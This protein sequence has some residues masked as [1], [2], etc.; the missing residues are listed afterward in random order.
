MLELQSVTYEIESRL[1]LREVSCSF[2]NRKYGLVGA[3][4]AGKT[5]LARLLAGE[6]MPSTGRVQRDA[7][8]ALLRQQEDRGEGRCGDVLAQ[9]WAANPAATKLVAGLLQ[10]LAAATRLSHLSGGEWMRLRLARA[11]ATSPSFLVL[12]EPTNDLDSDGREVVLRLLREFEGGV[13]AISHDRELLREVDEVLELKASGLAR[14]GAGFDSYWLERTAERERQ[15]SE[16]DRA[17]REKR[18]AGRERQAKLESQDR[19]ARGGERKAKAGGM[20]RIFAQ[21][22]KRRA[23]VTRGKLKQQ[24]D[25][26]VDEAKEELTEALAALETD[27]FMRLDFESEA[28]PESR[29][30]FEAR[31]LS[32]RFPGASEELWPGGLNFLMRGR[33]RWHLRGAN[34]SGKTTLL[35]LLMGEQAG[36][37][38]GSLWRSGRPFVY[39]DQGL[40]LLRD[41]ISVI[42]NFGE[43]S[44]FTPVTLRNE[45]A[46]YGFK[47]DKV[48]QRVG[49]LSGGERLRA[50]LAR[51][52]LS[53]AI[54]QMILLD[55]PTNNLDFQSMDLLEA[56]LSRYRGLLVLVSHDSVFVDQVAITDVFEIPQHG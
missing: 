39:L 46:F 2:G 40:T 10:P 26:A 18:T 56:A 5:T 28:S 3:N 22:Q 37:V 32:V 23:Q 20:P 27:P 15:S 24:S 8:V 19:K 34:G 50:A 7:V 35:R 33:Q 16:V 12:D 29:S 44:R 17:R 48:H 13:L 45:L 31:N 53:K 9:I 4:G 11:L 43:E 30:F 14:Y 25:A 51:C 38:S 42:E 36:D 55:E 52:F 47:G 1:I 54:P 6:V 41:D 21:A 49:T